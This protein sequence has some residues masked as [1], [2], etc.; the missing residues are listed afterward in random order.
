[1][2]KVCSLVLGVM[3]FMS[4][5]NVMAE[6][7]EVKAPKSTKSEAEVTKEDFPK[8]ND[9]QSICDNEYVQDEVRI[10]QRKILELLK[11]IGKASRKSEEDVEKIKGSLADIAEADGKID[12]LAS[13]ESSLDKANTLERVKNIL[14]LNL[15]GKEEVKKALDLI[16]AVE[17]ADTFQKVRDIPRI[18]RKINE[19]INKYESLEKIVNQA[20]TLEKVKKIPYINSK[21]VS[22]IQRIEK[23]LS[24]I[25]ILS[26]AD[27]LINNSLLSKKLK[28]Q[29]ADLLNLETSI[30]DADNFDKIKKL[31]NISQD[32]VKYV[33]AQLSENK[34][35][36]QQEADLQKKISDVNYRLETVT[37]E[38]ETER[39]FLTML[40]AVILRALIGFDYRNKIFN[41]E[42]NKELKVAE[43][44]AMI[45]AS[46]NRFS[47]LGGTE[48][49][50]CVLT[51]GLQ[52]ILKVLVE[53]KNW[54]KKADR[55]KIKLEAI[56][57]LCRRFNG[58]ADIIK[59]N[60]DHAL[61]IVSALLQGSKRPPRDN[62]QNFD[63]LAE[64]APK[65]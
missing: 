17:D 44:S 23:E 40:T 47:H 22:E 65:E 60:V 56:S 7:A 4:G 37:Q 46:R 12:Y 64:Q 14:G 9:L 61:N 58:D 15:T 35:L 20:D 51:D 26:N 52:Q 5:Y 45:A 11:T 29:V 34:K 21:A 28:D 36:K 3:F 19:V 43:K 32:F 53:D 48:K 8:F 38:S 2:K 42:K 1:M 24:K 10:L 55:I 39:R 31:P 49:D 63:V 50:L 25:E 18:N 27:Q 54:M 41:F 6:S 59:V 62:V 33:E 30:K 16:E 57:T 13:L